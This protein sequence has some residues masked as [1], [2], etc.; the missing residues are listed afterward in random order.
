MLFLALVPVSAL[1]W[2]PANITVPPGYVPRQVS[3]DANED[4]EVYAV[5][6]TRSGVGTEL[7]G[8]L[9][10]GTE[11]SLDAGLP[12]LTND[13]GRQAVRRLPS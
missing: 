5:V 2:T 3:I 7:F 12:V 6:D 11:V 4:D 10:D 13:G 9:P 8:I 1:A